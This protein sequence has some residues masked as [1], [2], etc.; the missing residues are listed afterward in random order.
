MGIIQMIPRFQLGPWVSGNAIKRETQEKEQTEGGKMTS[1][2]DM[3]SLQCLW[4]I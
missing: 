2:L 4:D 1:G 3:L